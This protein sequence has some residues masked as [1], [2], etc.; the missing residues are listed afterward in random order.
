MPLMARAKKIIG[1]FGNNDGNSSASM[2]AE[3]AGIR[4]GLEIHLLGEIEHP[5]LGGCTDLPAIPKSPADGGN[6]KIQ[7]LGQLF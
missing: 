2:L 7:L 6:R 4:I 5:L 3:T 1:Y